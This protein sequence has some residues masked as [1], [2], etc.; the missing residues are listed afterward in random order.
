MLVR[1]RRG[2]GNLVTSA[3]QLLLV[4]FALHDGTRTGVL[5]S[6]FL[7]AL[8]SFFVWLSAVRRARAIGDTPTARVASCAQGYAE[9][10]G[11]GKPL[12][13]LPLLSP[14]TGLPCLWYRYRVERRENDKWVYDSS[15]E[16]DSSF[17]LDDGT[18][19][20]L[21]DPEGAEMLVDRHDTWRQGDRRYNQWLLIANDP[22]YALGEF[23]TR[24][25]VEL[26]QRHGED[27]KALLAEWKQDRKQ[28][29]ARFD[30]NGDGEIDL[31][32]WE[33]ARAEAKRHV[34]KEHREA[35]AHAELHLMRAPADG[36][37]YLISSLDPDRLAR[38][39]RGWSVFHLVVFLA[40]VT[41]LAY[42][43]GMPA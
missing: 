42:G 41:G 30:R 39:F 11:R 37:L 17:I 1:L 13:G 9:L 2:Y 4:G 23:V 38:R 20:C 29:L 24:G 25:T 43:W 18:A 5:V 21:V 22:L 14:L 26:D 7:I 6:A 33:L 31:H 3:A 15:G 12:G 19:E 16:S 32:E 28:L 8:L 35:R 34:T 36:R 10:R 40:G 27:I